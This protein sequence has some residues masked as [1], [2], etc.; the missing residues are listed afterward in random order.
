MSLKPESVPQ[1]TP[2]FRLEVLDQE[3]ILLRPSDGKIV[4]CNETAG[5]VFRLCDANRSVQEIAHLLSEAYPESKAQVAN[6]VHEAL[7]TLVAAD[8]IIII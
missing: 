5:L 3:V 7:S 6:D 1:Q 8:V 2:G 4:Q